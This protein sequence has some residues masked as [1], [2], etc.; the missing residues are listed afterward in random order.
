MNLQTSDRVSH[1]LLVDDEKALRLILRRAMMG[2]GYQ[3]TEAHNGEQCLLACQ[4]Q[5]P[6]LIL[7]DAV[8]PGIDGFECCHQLQTLFGERCPPILMITALYDQASVDRAFEAGATDYITKPILWAV[9]R[10]RVRRLIQTHQTE[11][12]LK[13]ALERE[14]LLVEQLA[15]A[16]Q[17]LQQ[18]DLG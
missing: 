13:Q 16:K 17:Q 4:R 11:L 9:L 18:L 6:D 2:E 15:A 8:M 14:G 5:V 3:V 10:Q 7:L 1:I 12:A